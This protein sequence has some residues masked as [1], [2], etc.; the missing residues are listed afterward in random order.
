MS[1]HTPSLMTFYAGWGRS[2]RLLARMI[3]P[4]SREQLAL[5][6]GSHH[7]SIGSVVQHLVGNRVWWFQLWMGQGDPDLAPLAHWDPADVE[8]TPVSDPGELIAGLETTWELVAGALDGW[9]Q[10][11]LARVFSPP[12]ALTEE[13]REIFGPTSMEWIIWHVIEHE[14]LH[15]GELSLALGSYDLPGF[16]GDA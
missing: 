4:L 12:D 7:W 11:D 9:T 14:I 3:A 6:A 10:T 1:E 5:P 13:E 8:H 16:Y 15:A 2:Q